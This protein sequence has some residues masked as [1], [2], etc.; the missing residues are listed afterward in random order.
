MSLISSLPMNWVLS[1]PLA[2]LPRW[3]ILVPSFLGRHTEVKHLEDI[4]KKPSESA[5]SLCDFFSNNGI[6]LAVPKKKVSH[7]KKRQ[8]LYAPARKQLKMIHHLNQCPSCG[9]YKRA[10]TLCMHCVGEI[11]HI[12]KTHT[13]K[14][15]LEPPQEQNM[16]D[17]DKR[18]L[19][20]GKKDTEYM[21]KLKDKDTYL[22]RR[23]KPLPVEK[24][25]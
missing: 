10:N 18:I 20:P 1:K 8:K 13:A 23:M 6:L 7:Q 2:I 3:S 25:N 14:E 19:Y 16:S 11:R 24:K 17:L 9:H 22:E 4:L 12:W 21:K 5:P 15:V